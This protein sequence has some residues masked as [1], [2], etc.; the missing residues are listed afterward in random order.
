MTP[1]YIASLLIVASLLIQHM[2]ITKETQ[3][4]EHFHRVWRN[5]RRQI[6]CCRFISFLGLMTILAIVMEAY[7]NV[8]LGVTESLV[9]LL[10]KKEYTTLAV[11]TFFVAILH[12]LIEDH[13]ET[14]MGRSK[15]EV[16]HV[17]LR[18][19]WLLWFSAS[20][21]L[22][23]FLGGFELLD[24]TNIMNHKYVLG[25]ATIVIVTFTYDFW[26]YNVL[27]RQMTEGDGFTNSAVSRIYGVK[28]EM[29][30]GHGHDP[31]RGF[32]GF[33]FRAI[34]YQPPAQVLIIG[35][36][37]AGKT[38]WV[39]Q[40]DAAF[41][42]Y[43]KSRSGG[44]AGLQSTQRIEYARDTENV[45]IVDHN[46]AID[47]EFSVTLLDF[48]G[49]NLGDHCN[50][51]FELRSDVLI[52]ILP[53][54]AFNPQ[55][56]ERPEPFSVNT[57]QDI[58]E[59]FNGGAESS[60]ARDYMYA[61]YF[62]LQMDEI[63]QEVGRRQQSG[64]GAFVLLVNCRDQQKYTNKFEMHIKSLSEQMARKFGVVGD[65][66]VFSYYYDIAKGQQPVLREAIRS[67][68]KTIEVG[69]IGG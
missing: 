13:V 37:G 47:A 43:V 29:G 49:E 42:E 6:L 7:H 26:I 41:M 31:I 33:L 62:G 28:Q 5:Y 24:N 61:L 52:L 55:L 21:V 3:Q 56:D 46:M 35:P 66:R 14:R 60:R 51:P 22:S 27:Y 36:R 11:L 69:E 45:N 1:A 8:D 38:H 10:Q 57:S 44:D 9:E 2:T 25:V 50:L 39:M 67:L 32:L 20:I 68:H 63:N 64:V 17:W 19:I 40:R 16:K 30:E 4:R 65:Q 12:L 53:E 59:Y 54:D 48:P 23:V 15:P 58:S 18:D 34:Q